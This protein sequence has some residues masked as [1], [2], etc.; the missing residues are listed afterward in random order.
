MPRTSAGLGSLIWDIASIQKC[1]IPFRPSH[2]LSLWMYTHLA[3]ANPDGP[4]FIEKGTFLTQTDSAS[5]T[6]GLINLAYFY[7]EYILRQQ[8]QGSREQP[9]SR[10]TGAV[11][12][13]A[14]LIIFEATPK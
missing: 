5:G 6:A 12:L 3:H 1:H 10:P 4:S 13:E 8:S 9:A 2:G 14:T 7:A 11:Q